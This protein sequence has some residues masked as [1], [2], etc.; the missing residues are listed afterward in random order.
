MKACLL[1]RDR[2]HDWAATPAWNG[3]A[4]TTDLAL[5]SLF[6]AMAAGDDGI[7]KVVD[8]VILA[9][10]QNDLETIDHR[11][12]V[13]ADSL[14]HPRMV[15]EL[16]A[17][18]LE[19]ADLDRRRHYYLGSLDRH[20]EWV[21]SR[22]VDL[23]VDQIALLKRLRR[24]VTREAGTLNSTGWT[25]FIGLIQSELGDA[26]FHRA[27]AQLADLRFAGGVVMSAGFGRA[28][29]PARYL[30]H[31]PPAQR[32]LSWWR[33]L[34]ARL[35][36]PKPPPNSFDINPR[37]ESGI[38]ALDIM[39]R[40]GLAVVANALARSA[41]HLVGFFDETRRELA[42]YV[43]CLNLYEALAAK[44]C[45]VCT[46]G[47]QAA[48]AA[49]ALAFQGLYDPT[50]ALAL[51]GAV[52][53][54]DAD[55]D[56]ARLIMVTGANQ[57]GKSTFLRGVGLAQLMGQAGLFAPAKSFHASLCD[58]VFTHFKR[59]EDRGLEAGKFDEEL[60]RLSEI[61]DYLTPRPLLLFNES[62]AAT[63]EREGAEIGRQ[64]LT[65][66]L[67]GP[68]RIVCVTHIYELGRRFH[69]E[70]RADVRFL[71]AERREDGTRTFKLVE[72][73]PFRTSFAADL[74]REVFGADLPRHAA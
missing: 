18:C 72:G 39:R 59:E 69:E 66:L 12:G 22:S 58:G 70:H 1:Y 7:L 52:V 30:L 44:G 67:E 24:L 55:L 56:G 35:W 43:G 28:N 16:Y 14:V 68:R 3:P 21:L 6:S 11:Q 73:A 26:F 42:F 64:V 4:L 33:G 29:K 19:A 15:R 17:L 32:R 48:D 38:R 62:F 37:D 47:L 63:N 2:A 25:T 9:A 34:L 49:S 51:E 61:V 60:R 10:P 36:P 74:Y 41:D 65:A 40:E 53:G 54:N 57:G 8:K 50:L 20:P 13:L 31:A 27:Q 46:P 45:E 71:R 23:M 5:D